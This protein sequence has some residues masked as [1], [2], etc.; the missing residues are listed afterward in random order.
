MCDGGA[1]ERLSFLMCEISLIFKLIFFVK[2]SCI[3]NI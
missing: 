2:K 1:A 3:K